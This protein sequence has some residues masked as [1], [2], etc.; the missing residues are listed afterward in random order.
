MEP[1]E[2]LTLL[3]HGIQLYATRPRPF[4]QVQCPRQHAGTPH[5]HRLVTDFEQSSPHLRR[6]QH[7]P[8][9]STRSQHQRQRFQAH[10]VTSSTPLGKSAALELRA[11]EG[12]APSGVT[13]HTRNTRFYCCHH[14]RRRYWPILP[15]ISLEH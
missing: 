3:K 6:P 7:T 1:R 5:W 12:R 10:I 4:P 2:G 14:P 8:I 13:R 15:M 11:S 9:N